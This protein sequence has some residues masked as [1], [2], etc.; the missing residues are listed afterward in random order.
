MIKRIKN[1]LATLVGKNVSA[2]FVFG[3]KPHPYAKAVVNIPGTKTV[4][5]YDPKSFGSAITAAEMLVHSTRTGEMFIPI[6]PSTFSESLHNTSVFLG[7]ECLCNPRDVHENNIPSVA[8]KS[9]LSFLDMD[10]TPYVR[11]PRGVPI[12][13]REAGNLIALMAFCNAM[14]NPDAYEL[15][16][17]FSL[18]TGLT[19]MLAQ[20]KMK[21]KAVPMLK[22][23]GSFKVKPRDPVSELLDIC[24]NSKTKSWVVPV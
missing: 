21:I 9:L 12:P 7:M 17:K 15:D 13:Q 8:I 18:S 14:L 19:W 22:G 20:T 6:T 1:V 16:E 4:V 24:Y 3:L 23:N 5:Y 11:V 10:Y 2:P